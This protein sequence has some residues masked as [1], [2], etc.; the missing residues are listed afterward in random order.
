MTYE[1]AADIMI[2]LKPRGD[3][4][5]N[6]AFDHFVDYFDMTDSQIEFFYCLCGFDVD[7]ATEYREKEMRKAND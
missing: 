6:A 3:R 2:S 5:I 1:M 7:V 4:L